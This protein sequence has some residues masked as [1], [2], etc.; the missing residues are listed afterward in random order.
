MKI[1]TVE[2]LA[3]PDIDR[4]LV[5]RLEAAFPP[6]CYDGRSKLEAHLMYAGKVELVALLRDIMDAQA[7]AGLEIKMEGDRLNLE[8]QND[9]GA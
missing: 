9:D 7:E 1:D 5:E 4:E 2:A 8:I 6:R 3:W